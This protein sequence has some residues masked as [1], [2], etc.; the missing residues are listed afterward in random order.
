[1]RGGR[2]GSANNPVRKIASA[3]RAE[4]LMPLADPKMEQVRCARAAA[5]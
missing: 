5:P 3:I 1:M 2:G 4:G